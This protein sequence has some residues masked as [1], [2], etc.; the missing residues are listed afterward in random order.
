MKPLTMRTLESA[1]SGGN[2]EVGANDEGFHIVDAS[3]GDSVCLDE[4][5]ATGLLSVLTEAIGVPADAEDAYVRGFSRGFDEGVR[6][7][8]SEVWEAL[9]SYIGPR[10]P[11]DTTDDACRLPVDA[12]ETMTLAAVVGVLTWRLA[13]LAQ[14]CRAAVSDARSD[15]ATSNGPALAAFAHETASDLEAA[16]CEAEAMP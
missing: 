7:A 8:E 12:R 13:R 2:L 3:G 6:R 5:Q 10:G 4:G 11:L 9:G 16:L 1:G 14:A 15:A